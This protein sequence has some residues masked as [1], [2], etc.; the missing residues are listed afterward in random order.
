MTC[1][2]IYLQTNPLH[3]EMHLIHKT[4]TLIT[5][6]QSSYF[7]LVSFS[8]SS[9]STQAHEKSQ[10]AY[11]RRFKRQFTRKSV[12][13]V[14]YYAKD[15]GKSLGPMILSK[16]LKAYGK[17]EGPNSLQHLKMILLLNSSSP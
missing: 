3:F 16:G 14:L 5:L 6:N 12:Y 9:H 1:T 10:L 13:K 15:Q 7:Q 17:Q 11:F 2:F 4:N 8:S